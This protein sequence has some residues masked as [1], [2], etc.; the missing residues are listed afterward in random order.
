MQRILRGRLTFTPRVNALHPLSDKIESGE[1]D[2]RELLKLGELHVRELEGYDFVGPTRFD[3]LFSG[4]AVERPK[5]VAGH[6]PAGCEGIGPEDTFDGDYGRLLDRVCVKRVASPAGFGK[7][8]TMPFA[9]EA[10]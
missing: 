8:C 2:I 5:Y 1:L 7:G 6:I 3:K 10:A 4:I 9:C